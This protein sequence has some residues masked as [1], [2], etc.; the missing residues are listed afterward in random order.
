MATA[1]RPDIAARRVAEL[2]RQTVRDRAIL[3]LPEPITRERDRVNA[4]RSISDAR[5]ESIDLLDSLG[6]SLADVFGKGAPLWGMERRAVRL[7]MPA[8][9]TWATHAVCDDAHAA[10][11]EYCDAVVDHIADIA[12][13][14]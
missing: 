13:V 1:I 5:E 12:V 14:S 10:R 11:D 8:M 2:A 9:T 7:T 4:R 3:A 6:L